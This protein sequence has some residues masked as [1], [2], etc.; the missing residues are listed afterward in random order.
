VQAA[1]R[2]LLGRRGAREGEQLLDKRKAPKRSATFLL[3]PSTAAAATL[4]LRSH[5]AIIFLALGIPSSCCSIAIHPQ[6]LQRP[7]PCLR[8]LFRA[9]SRARP[10]WTWCG[11]FWDGPRWSAPGRLGPVNPP[12]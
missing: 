7:S 11:A 6:Q 8:S 4:H 9:G 1:V 2:L 12:P 10:S 3:L 5:F